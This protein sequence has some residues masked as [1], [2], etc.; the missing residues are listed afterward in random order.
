[1][2]VNLG[3]TLREE[4]KLMTFKNGVLRRVFGPKWQKVAGDWRRLHNEELHNFCA[5]RNI[6]R[7]IKSKRI[8][9]VGHVAHMGETRNSYKILAEKPEWKRPLGRPRR[10]WKNTIRMDLQK[11]E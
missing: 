1:M 10:R 7:V 8:K 11:I 6:I 3:L 2:G 5:S 4:H 9:W